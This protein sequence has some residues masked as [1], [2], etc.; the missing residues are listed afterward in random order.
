MRNF[1][2]TVKYK[3][4]GKSYKEKLWTV[5]KEKKKV[6]GRESE[7]SYASLPLYFWKKSHKKTTS[8]H[9]DLFTSLTT[10]FTGN[11]AAAAKSGPKRETQMWKTS[12]VRGARRGPQPFS[13]PTILG[14]D[15]IIHKKKEKKNVSA[16]L[17]QLEQK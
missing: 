10:V 2:E 9:N 12:V 6:A 1:R 17:A 16:P 15:V 11:H 8:N 5:R 7:L 4:K 13:L 3:S 14:D